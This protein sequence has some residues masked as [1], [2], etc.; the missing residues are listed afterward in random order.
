[1]PD[2]DPLLTLCSILWS[3]VKWLCMP[4][5]EGAY[6]HWPGHP[7]GCLGVWA[8]TPAKV[9][10]SPL[11]VSIAWSQHGRSLGPWQTNKAPDT[12]AVP[13][14]R[15]FSRKWNWTHWCSFP[16]YFVKQVTESNL[17]P[18]AFP[19]PTCSCP[20][21]SCID[22]IQCRCGAWTHDRRCSGDY[23]N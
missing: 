23:N 15:N 3:T 6:K 4:S 13:H 1:M 10:Q 9:P 12:G 21:T 7:Q 16:Y 19:S 11:F 8:S 5:N 2:N 14:I 20:Y 17:G 22:A 18:N